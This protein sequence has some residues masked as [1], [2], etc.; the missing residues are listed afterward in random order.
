M[1]QKNREK[2]SKNKK[3]IAFE[4]ENGEKKF[5]VDF[6]VTGENKINIFFSEKFNK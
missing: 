2:L 5:L 6:Y 4:M 1:V 3:D